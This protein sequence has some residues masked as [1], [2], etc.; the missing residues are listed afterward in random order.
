MLCSFTERP[1]EW[2]EGTIG[3]GMVGRGVVNVCYCKSLWS[4]ERTT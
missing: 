4:G 1:E 2:N 3:W